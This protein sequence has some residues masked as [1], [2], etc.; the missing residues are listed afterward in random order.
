MAVATYDPGEVQ[1]IIGGT[2]ISGYADGTF[3]NLAWASDLFT[4]TVGADGEVSRAKSNDRTGTLTLTLLQTSASNDVLSGYAEADRLSNSG[5]VPVLI[6]DASGRTLLLATG[7]VGRYPDVNFAKDDQQ[8]A[9]QIHLAQVNAF[10]GG[11]A[12]STAN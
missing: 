12:D 5:V 8:R 2:P 11:N 10:I 3:V 6:K 1:C 4:K 9:W 7:W